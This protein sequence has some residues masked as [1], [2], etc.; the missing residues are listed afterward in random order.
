MAPLRLTPVGTSKTVMPSSPLPADAIFWVVQIPIVQ[1]LKIQ[2]FRSPWHRR[3]IL[4]AL[5][6]S[7]LWTFGWS[8]CFLLITRFL[9]S[10]SAQ[11]S[12][13]FSKGSFSA[14]Q[15]WGPPIQTRLLTWLQI[16]PD[17]T[18]PS[19]HQLKMPLGLLCLPPS[20][21]HCSPEDNKHFRN[22]FRDSP[23]G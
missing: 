18:F 2:G 14:T 13:R 4:G 19:F 15:V 17:P 6:L 22:R 20:L 11:P 9:P 23:Q 5:K 1:I 3:N 16:G 12:N 8:H 21:I 7:Y 10:G